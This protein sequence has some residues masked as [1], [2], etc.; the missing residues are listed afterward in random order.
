MPL[1]GGSTEDSNVFVTEDFDTVQPWLL[2]I[3]PL[4][5]ERVVLFSEA[6]V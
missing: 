5:K 4:P 2:W 1:D 6:A 3:L